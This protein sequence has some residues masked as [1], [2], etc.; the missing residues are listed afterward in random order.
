M[1]K[2]GIKISYSWG[3]E[4]PVYGE[5][6]TAIDAF[7]AACLLA[8]KEAYVQNDELDP[9]KT[10]TIEVDACLQ[11]INLHYH[12]DDEWCYYRIVELEDDSAEASDVEEHEYKIEYFETYTGIYTATAK[13]EEDAI[14]NLRYELIEYEFPE[15]EMS[16]SGFKVL[17]VY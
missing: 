17:K 9:S 16:D 3:D 7:S 4:E 13:T 8:G 14:E 11:I 12:G 5:Y 15:L 10:C 6:D 2:Y 1:S